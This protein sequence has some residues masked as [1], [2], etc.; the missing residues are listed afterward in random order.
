MELFV[1][2]L[3]CLSLWQYLNL[4]VVGPLYR[5]LPSTTS[6]AVV[7]THDQIAASLTSLYNLFIDLGYS[8]YTDFAW[9][10]HSPAVLNRTKCGEVGLDSSAIGLLEKIPWPNGVQAWTI[11]VGYSNALNFTD[12]EELEDN[13]DPTY[14]KIFQ[15]PSY[16]CDREHAWLLPLTFYD[17]ESDNC[18]L[19]DA[20]AGTIHKLRDGGYA[21]DNGGP[22]GGHYQNWTGKPTLELL[23]SLYEEYYSLET[24]F[25]RGP[26]RLSGVF[27]RNH[28]CVSWPPIADPSFQYP[29]TQIFTVRPR[30][31]NDDR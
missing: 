16:V 14:Y 12:A 1:W 20:Q 18:F 25:I 26:E 24:I 6:P 28:P 5:Y 3:H 10:P 23:E 31:S 4:P 21:E 9:P 22:S 27:G 30:K 11:L 2:L 13:C 29:L 7:N 8:E 19:V 15:D 17:G